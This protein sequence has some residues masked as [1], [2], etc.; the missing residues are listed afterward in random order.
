MLEVDKNLNYSAYDVRVN[1]MST[2]SIEV[3]WNG[4]VGSSI[5]I[6]CNCTSTAL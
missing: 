3:I 1:N 4:K 5:F 6:K 2:N